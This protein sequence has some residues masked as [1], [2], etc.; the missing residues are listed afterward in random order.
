MKISVLGVFCLRRFST[1]F[2]FGLFSFLFIFFSFGWSLCRWQ[3]LTAHS[4]KSD[5]SAACNGSVA[6]WSGLTTI[7][8]R[9]WRF[10]FGMDVGADMCICICIGVVMVWSWFFYLSRLVPTLP[11]LVHHHTTTHDN[12]TPACGQLAS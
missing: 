11:C 8:Q 9:F 2:L 1:F 3:W 4:Q 5:M 12:T 6:S 7:S 10:S